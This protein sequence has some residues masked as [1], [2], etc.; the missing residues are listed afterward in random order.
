MPRTP[1]EKCV[2]CDKG[3]D[4]DEMRIIGADLLR[5]F[6][7]ILSTK[8]IGLKDCVCHRCRL[9]F[10]NWEREMKGDFDGYGP[11]DKFNNDYL[12][13]ENDD[14]V[15]FLEFYFKCF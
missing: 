3:F 2:V 7:A 1:R 14:I 15:I 10:V 11:Q 12:T 6:L 5:I 9:Q 4:P 13:N 8:R